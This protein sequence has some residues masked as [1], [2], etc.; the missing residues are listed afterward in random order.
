MGPMLSLGVDDE[1]KLHQWKP[2]AIAS[3]LLRKR[4]G[5][6]SYVSGASAVGLYW[7]YS[8][9]NMTGSS[10][11]PVSGFYVIVVVDAELALSLGDLSGEFVKRLDQKIP[12]AESSLVSRRE[13]V[14]GGSV[15]S[16]RARFGD[17]GRE[18]DILI[19][20]KGDGGGWDASESELVVSVDKKRVV[21]VRRL[22]WNFRGNQTIFI[23][24][25]PVDMMWD[26]GSWWFS[27]PPGHAVF[28]F[29]RRSALQSRLWLEE[30]MLHK[31]RGVSGFSLIIQAFKN[32]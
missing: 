5:T 10:P 23:D 26:V 6:R 3:H 9:S 25:A 17:G 27:S 4:K 21:Q 12:T 2:N 14:L 16:T 13:Q 24:G 29:R 11:E 22:Q 28:M 8:A 1:P 7:D 32:P 30:E 20:C 15:Y 18:H 19:R 31:E